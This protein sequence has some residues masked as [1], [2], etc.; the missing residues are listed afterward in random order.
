VT[1]NYG[2]LIFKKNEKVT[3][4]GFRNEIAQTNQVMYLV[5]DELNEVKCVLYVHAHDMYVLCRV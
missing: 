1:V 5:R 3:V 4:T 2:S